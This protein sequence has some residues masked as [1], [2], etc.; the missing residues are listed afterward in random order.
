[1]TEHYAYVAVY[2]SHVNLGLYHGAHI[3]CSSVSLDG[4]GKNL[5]HI[6]CRAI[7]DTKVPGLHSVIRIAYK[8]RSAAIAAAGRRRSN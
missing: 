3:T 2:A 5:R 4:T 6:K 1:M 7:A 8:E